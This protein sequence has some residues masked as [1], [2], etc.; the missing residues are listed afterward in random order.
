MMETFCLEDLYVSRETIEQL[1]KYLDLL[2]KWNH[3]INLVS[4]N[5][6][7]DLWDRHVLDSAQLLRFY[8]CKKKN[9]VDLGSGAGFPGIVISII[10][11][12]KFPELKMTLIESDKRKC[13]FLSEV[14]RKLELNI[15]IIPNR[16][17]N[18]L[19]LHADII[20]ARA[21]APIKKL[22]SFFVLHGN[23]DCKGLFLKGKN[24]HHEL[25]QVVEFNKFRIKVNSSLIN[26]TGF[27]V[28][29]EKR[30]Y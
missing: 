27:V 4:K 22:L 18:C 13:A 26:S 23:Q 3:T 16:I 21:L 10:A 9:W 12:E 7:P 2:K 20:S 8:I 14:A 25:S 19:N 1:N 30:N 5:S 29:V 11:K 17:E 6:I 28:E 24:V 15:I